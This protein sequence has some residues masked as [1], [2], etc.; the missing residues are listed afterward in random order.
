M[1]NN[2]QKKWIFTLNELDAAQLPSGNDLQEFLNKYAA[3]G[4]FGLEKSS[5]HRS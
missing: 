2:R 5:D 4:V 3:E 1:A